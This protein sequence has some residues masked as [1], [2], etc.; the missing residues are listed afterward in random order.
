MGDQYD[1]TIGEGLL[2]FVVS[3]FSGG[4]EEWGLFHIPLLAQAEH[5]SKFRVQGW[6]VG[7]RKSLT[8]V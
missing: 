1:Q 6:K 4:V 7:W 2:F 5:G 3:L 8:K